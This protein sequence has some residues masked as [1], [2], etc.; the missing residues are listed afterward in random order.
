MQLSAYQTWKSGKLQVQKTK[1]QILASVMQQ[2]KD[3]EIQHL[4]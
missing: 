3:F 4:Y 2:M 1:L